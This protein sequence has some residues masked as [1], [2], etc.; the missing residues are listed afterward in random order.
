VSRVDRLPPE[1]LDDAQRALYDAITSGPRARGPQHFALT[2]DDGGLAGPFDGFLRSPAIGEALQGVGAAIRY[3]SHL[4]GRVREGAIL[5]VAAHWASTFEQHAHEAV[6][7]SIGLDDE[8]LLALGRGAVPASSDAGER[9]RLEVVQALLRGD[10]TDDEWARL[11][12]VVGEQDLFELI[13]LVG[14]Y[15]TLALQL[16]V[17]RVGVEE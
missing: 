16:R 3:R 2:A 15:A 1:R 12:P 9:A 6:G 14:Y 11:S 10:L 4:A 13:A 17:L 5:L 7:R 8:D